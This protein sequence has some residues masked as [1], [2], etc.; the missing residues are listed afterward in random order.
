MTDFYDLY[1][2]QKKQGQFPP[3]KFWLCYIEGTNGG[4][5]Y[6]HYNLYAAQ[7]EA[8]RLAHINPSKAV[9]LLECIGKCKVIENPVKW[10][11]PR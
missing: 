5:H 1:L 4:S 2:R 9:Y 8:E 11:I 7:K 3:L 10:E 6:R